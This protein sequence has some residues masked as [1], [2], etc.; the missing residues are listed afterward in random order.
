MELPSSYRPKKT[1]LARLPKSVL[2]SL[3]VKS[4]GIGGFDLHPWKAVDYFFLFTF[5][6]ILIAMIYIS[7]T[8]PRTVTVT[9]V[10]QECAQ[11]FEGEY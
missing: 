4:D 9:Y 3:P 1:I 10:P 6:G 8:T 5:T 7:Q 2:D 11:L